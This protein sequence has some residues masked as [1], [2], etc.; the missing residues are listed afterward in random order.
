MF[1]LTILL[2]L[3]TSIF[4]RPD[5]ILSSGLENWDATQLQKQYNN[6]ATYKD[7]G[8]ITA[9]SILVYNLDIDGNLDTYN[10]TD[11]NM[12]AEEY[13][14][15]V[16]KLGLGKKPTIYCDSTINKCSNLSKRL[17]RLYTHSQDFINTTLQK[18]QKY[19]YDGYIVDFE[20]DDQVDWTKLTSFLLE[21]SSQLSLLNL[22][23]YVW[24]GSGTPYENS[25]YTSKNIKVLT[26]DTY[27]SD[28]AS[29]VE[30]ASTFVTKKL[31]PANLGFGLL[32]SN[33][34]PEKDMFK[35]VK[36]CEFVNVTTL[37]IWASTIDGLSF[38][39]LHK[40]LTS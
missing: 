40:F 11:P 38:R 3:V 4:A 8:I 33:V 36:W 12:T 26:M 27:T 9:S 39:P 1:Y 10:T 32:T 20:A 29:F 21:W 23:L 14:V 35:I 2:M 16:G 7:L 19:G 37:S 5:V 15:S 22:S 28:F 25:L 18:A 13:Q 17:D 30:E 34:V 31:N 6:F 24:V